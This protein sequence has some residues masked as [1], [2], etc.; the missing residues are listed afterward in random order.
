VACFHGL[1]NQTGYVNRIKISQIIDY[2]PVGKIA[3]KAVCS[4]MTR[5]FEC[6]I[7]KNTLLQTNFMAILPTGNNPNNIVFSYEDASCFDFYFT[8]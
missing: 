7:N 3:E 6:R 4:D 5:Y 1:P 8:K 2:N